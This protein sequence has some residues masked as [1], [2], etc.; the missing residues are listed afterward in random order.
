MSDPKCDCAEIP[1]CDCRMCEAVEPP[2]CPS[3]AENKHG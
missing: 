1:E 2:C 3:C